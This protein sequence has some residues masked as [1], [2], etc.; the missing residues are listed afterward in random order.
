MKLSK[1]RVLRAVKFGYY[2][3][4]KIADIYDVSEKTVRRRVNE[5][6]EEGYNIVWSKTE[7]AYLLR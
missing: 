3:P 6:R 4:Q 1:K 5:L 2:S 7:N